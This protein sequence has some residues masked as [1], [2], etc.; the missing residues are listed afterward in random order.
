MW[1]HIYNAI[2]WMSVKLNAPCLLGFIS[3]NSF[4][5]GLA[6]FASISTIL[7]NGI[8]IYKEL[9]NKKQ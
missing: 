6:A 4:L 2:D 9:K 1:H 3:G 7:Y 8:R 5:V